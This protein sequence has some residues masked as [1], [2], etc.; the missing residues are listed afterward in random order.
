L[1]VLHSR[2]C[3]HIYIYPAMS[4]L[5]VHCFIRCVIK[6]ILSHPA[7]LYIH[8]CVCIHILSCMFVHNTCM[9]TYTYMQRNAM[10]FTCVM[11]QIHTY[12]HTEAVGIVSYSSAYVEPYMTICI[13]TCIHTLHHYMYIHTEAVGPVSY[14]SAHVEPYMAICIK[15]CIQTYIHTCIHTEAVGTVSYS[16]AYV[17]PYMAAVTPRDSQYLGSCMGL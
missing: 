4:S 13:N 14:S 2:T 6:I 16:S 17:E 1:L 5:M 15:T 9:H 11:L 7:C 8:I 3:M 10:A 12:I